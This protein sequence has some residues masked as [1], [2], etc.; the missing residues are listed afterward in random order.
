MLLGT[1][2]KAWEWLGTSQ[3]F[4]VNSHGIQVFMNCPGIAESTCQGHFWDPS[5]SEYN[6]GRFF[7]IWLNDHSIEHITDIDNSNLH[8]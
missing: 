5:V 8:Y 6:S 1:L 3:F 4:T 2:G 7:Q